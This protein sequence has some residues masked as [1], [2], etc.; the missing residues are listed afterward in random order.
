MTTIDY[1]HWCKKPRELSRNKATLLSRGNHQ[2]RIKK[3]LFSRSKRWFFKDGQEIELDANN[4]FVSIIRNWKLKIENYRIP[5]L[6]SRGFVRILTDFNLKIWKNRRERNFMG[7]MLYAYSASLSP[8]D[9]KDPS[10]KAWRGNSNCNNV[11][12]GIRYNGFPRGDMIVMFSLGN[13]RW[14]CRYKIRLCLPRGRKRDLQRQ[15]PNQDCKIYCTISLQRMHE[16]DNSKRN[17]RNNFES[18]KYHNEKIW[19]AFRRMLDAAGIKYRQY[20]SDLAKNNMTEQNHRHRRHVG[21]GK[22]VLADEL[23]KRGGLC[24][25]RTTDDW[26]Y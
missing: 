7:R 24:A 16:D 13:A 3:T 19:V 1:C 9:S 17:Q 25:F 10:N 2:P 15:C 8:N 14:F 12:V 21:S 4:G 22:S 11:A 6:L 5:L 20:I 23:V 26:Y 18:D